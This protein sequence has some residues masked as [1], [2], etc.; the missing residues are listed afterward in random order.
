MVNT[1]DGFFSALKL[2]QNIYIWCR[3]FKATSIFVYN[4]I[5]DAEQK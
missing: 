1:T 2:F 3:S 4:V 5:M